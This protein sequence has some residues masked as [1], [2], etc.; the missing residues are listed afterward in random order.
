MAIEMGDEKLIHMQP[1]VA[2]QYTR[3]H[4]LACHICIY[5]TECNSDHHWTNKCVF[6]WQGVLISGG[7]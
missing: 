3:I 2:L 1:A 4:T 7:E 6:Y 5:S